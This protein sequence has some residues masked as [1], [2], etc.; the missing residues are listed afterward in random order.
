[1]VIC[2]VI[3]NYVVTT[4]YF[5]IKILQTEALKCHTVLCLFYHELGVTVLLSLCLLCSCRL[6]DFSEEQVED[7]EEEKQEDV[8]PQPASQSYA[9]T[10]ALSSTPP[11]STTLMGTVS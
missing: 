3:E 7:K 11:S 2:F 4:V 8:S 6:F 5:Y 10:V 1:M 9:A